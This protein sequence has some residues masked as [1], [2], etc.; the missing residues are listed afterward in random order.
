MTCGLAEVSCSRKPFSSSVGFWSRAGSR[1]GQDAGR[2]PSQPAGEMTGPTG[3]VCPFLLQVLMVVVEG[4]RWFT[5]CPLCY[6]HRGTFATHPQQ[7]REGS[8]R[9]LTTLFWKIHLCAYAIYSAFD[10]FWVSPVFTFLLLGFHPHGLCLSISPFASKT[11]QKPGRPPAP[12]PAL[13]A[14]QAP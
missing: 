11:E 12:Q 13:P 6:R 7:Q 1:G 3:P 10:F 4:S 8:S 5:G 2:E 9:A 14:P